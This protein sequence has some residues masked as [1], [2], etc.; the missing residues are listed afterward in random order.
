MAGAIFG[1]KVSE[2]Q[3]F[4]GS[5]RKRGAISLMGGGETGRLVSRHRT[6]WAAARSW[7]DWRSCLGGGFTEMVGW[8]AGYRSGMR[9]A[10]GV[11]VLARLGELLWGGARSWR[12]WANCLKVCLSPVPVSLSVRYALSPWFLL[13]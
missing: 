10:G 8:A 3:S 1:E 4:R 6:G 7:R 2:A 5:W 11:T 13:P 9:G 12:I